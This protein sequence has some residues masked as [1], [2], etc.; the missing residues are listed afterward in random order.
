MKF[1]A[2]IK[3]LKLQRSASEDMI[4][5]LT[6]ITENI[7]IMSLAAIPGDALVTVEIRGEDES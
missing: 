6:I 3:Q 1:T 2:Q 7:G 5:S 4:A